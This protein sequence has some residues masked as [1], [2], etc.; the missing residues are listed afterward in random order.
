MVFIRSIG[1]RSHTPDEK[2]RPEDLHAA[3]EVMLEALL[4]LDKQP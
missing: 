2:S 3:A 4:T 1:G